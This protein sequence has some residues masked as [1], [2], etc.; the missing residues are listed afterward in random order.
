MQRRRFLKTSGWGAFGSVVAP[1]VQAK[2]AK[3]RLKMLT[4]W[5]AGFPGLGTSAHRVARQIEAATGGEIAV[6]L[7]SA[8]ER[9]GPFDV[10]D[11]VA[12]GDA[13][14]YHS[15][16]YYQQEKSPAYNFF[17]AIPF[18][19]TAI[20]MAGWLLHGGG[21]ALWDEL[22]ARANVKPLLCTS[23]GA[24][25][26]GWFKR[27]IR[28]VSDFEGL[29]V[30]M[31]GLGGVAL[32]KLGAV[33]VKLAGGEIQAALKE[34][35]LQAAEWV[36]PWNDLAAG[37]HRA[38]NRYYYP[39][40]HEPGG[41]LTLGVNLDLW[42]SLDTRLQVILREVTTAEYIRSL[43]EFNVRN[44]EALTLLNDQH[45]IQPQP[46]DAAILSAIA[47]AA[48]EA[49]AEVAGA[50]ALTRQVHASFVEARDRAM[51]WSGIGE[52]A[53]TMARRKH[54]AG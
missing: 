24:Q 48:D 42:R 40:F 38:A 53:F 28:D 2:S 26:G 15:A 8:G 14:L 34:G 41:L 44:A 19:M 21:Q 17:T 22:A 6:R 37:M 23:T 45:N 1:A 16:D 7:F 29:R 12:V 3:L 33:P 47:V 36:G 11:A 30:R 10:F 35:S 5:P 27:E 49:V 20:E 18:G 54:Y 52:E 4:S 31:P 13:D 50:D 39:G 51:R 32:S 46:F 9:A 25:M 43:T